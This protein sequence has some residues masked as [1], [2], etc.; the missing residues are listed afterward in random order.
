MDVPL[1][2]SNNTVCLVTGENELLAV[3]TEGVERK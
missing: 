3:Y 2:R 1:D